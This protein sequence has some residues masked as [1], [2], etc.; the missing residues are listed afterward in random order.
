VQLLSS[1]H[2]WIAHI[3]L[4]KK[5]AATPTESILS[6][7]YALTERHGSMHAD[8]TKSLWH[9]TVDKANNF[10]AVLDFVLQR[11]V[12][13]FAGAAPDDAK[14]RAGAPCAAACCPS[15]GSPQAFFMPALTHRHPLVA[16]GWVT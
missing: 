6:L 10:S 8:E 2:P 1:L 16:L 7:L 4:D 11:V 15:L 9:M 12:D 3:E 5:W 13:A 14:V